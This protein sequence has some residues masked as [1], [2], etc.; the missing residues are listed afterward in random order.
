MRPEIASLVSIGACGNSIAGRSTGRFGA[1]DGLGAGKMASSSGTVW[2]TLLRTGAS[3]AAAEGGGGASRPLGV[4]KRPVV[5][6]I[7]LPVESVVAVD[8]RVEAS[9]VKV[10]VSGIGPVVGTRGA[11]AGRFNCVRNCSGVSLLLISAN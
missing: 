1:A 5:E 4:K 9:V 6:S 10:G 2:A 11:G 7:K 8:K 3:A